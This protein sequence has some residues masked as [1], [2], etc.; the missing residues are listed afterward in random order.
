MQNVW[1]FETDLNQNL[2][3]L[4]TSKKKYTLKNYK[5]RFTCNF[6]FFLLIRAFFARL[7]NSF[8]PH[9]IPPL[10]N[11]SWAVNFRFPEFNG[12][13]MEDLGLASRRKCIANCRL[14]RDGESLMQKAERRYNPSRSGEVKYPVVYGYM[15][16]RSSYDE[17]TKRKE[18]LLTKRL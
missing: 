11:S 1:K 15:A 2:V 14:V 8:F 3:I 18:V 4:N 12:K 6:P 13:Y 7:L 9:S 17:C 5:S 16:C 10:L